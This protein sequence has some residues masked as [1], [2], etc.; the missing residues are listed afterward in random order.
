ME[1]L[2]FVH[3]GQHYDPLLSDFIF[4]ELNLP[5][6][7]YHLKNIG[8][9]FGSQ[10]GHIIDY[11]GD[12]IKKESIEQVIVFGDTNTTLAG[13]IATTRCGV[14]LVH[15]EAGL[16]SGDYSMP[17]EVNRIWVDSVSD[18]LFAPSQKAVDCLEKA[19]LKPGAK[20]HKV[21]DIMYDVLK[22]VS[23]KAQESREPVHHAHWFM[24]LHRQSNTESL[25]RLLSVLEAV[26]TLAQENN[27]SVLFP[28]HPRTQKAID[29]WGIMESD[30]PSIQW[31][32]PLSYSQTLVCMERSEWVFTDSGGLQKEAFFLK[33]P[34][35]ILRDT[36]EWTEI[37]ELGWGALTH[38]QYSR[39][40]EALRTIHPETLGN[41]PSC[42][43]DGFAAK[44]M[45]KILQ[46]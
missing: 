41:P 42:Y 24:T 33:K 14:R 13:A 18:V 40:K 23:H 15:V 37:V 10:L 2:V 7:D 12:I 39:M 6:P 28:I 25:E 45:I 16:R 31:V 36:T 21:G 9:S 1:Q 3:S 46:E 44:S 27:K 43:G 20:I 4:S 32:K 8:S 19:D 34:V 30:F 26:N 17:E 11:I 38:G 35:I 5:K 22:T 29:K